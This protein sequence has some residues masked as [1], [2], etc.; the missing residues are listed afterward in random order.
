MKNDMGSDEIEI[1][2]APGWSGL[3]AAKRSSSH[4]ML[5]GL[6]CGE[7][8]KPVTVRL[9]G[10]EGQCLASRQMIIGRLVIHD[11]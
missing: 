5:K 7:G 10:G 4:R 8:T 2:S 11:R 9:S 3:L 6:I 1:P